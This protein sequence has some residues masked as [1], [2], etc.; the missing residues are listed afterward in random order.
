MKERTMNDRFGKPDPGIDEEDD[1]APTAE[2]P[3]RHEP[4]DP[5]ED[6]AEAPAMR[7]RG[8]VPVRRGL[9]KG[10]KV[11]LWIILGSPVLFLLLV[12]GLFLIKDEE[13]NSMWNRFMQN[14]GGSPV[15]EEERTGR[16]QLVRFQQDLE[17]G[18]ANIQFYAAE[19]DKLDA[20]YKAMTDPQREQLL[21][22]EAKAE[23]YVK[24][25]QNVS[26]DVAV[27]KRGVED[28]ERAGKEVSPSSSEV[29]RV[30]SDLDPILERGRKLQIYFGNEAWKTK[31]PPPPDNTPIIESGGHPK[32]EEE[33]KP[34]D[35]K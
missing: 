16:S 19:L 12:G 23:K 26:S 34:D 25:L 18:K 21:D 2:V 15:P 24:A 35:P 1:G 29:Q 4:R 6:T 22:L 27:L 33:K 9:S 8:A 32:K 28:F 14:V 17:S 5:A 7:R 30:L 10:D 3:Q 31:V 11:K 13:G 20:E